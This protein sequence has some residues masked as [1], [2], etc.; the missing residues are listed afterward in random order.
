PSEFD[1]DAQLFG[2]FARCLGGRL[3]KPP[4][5]GC[6]GVPTASERV[7]QH[8]ALLQQHLLAAVAQHPA[9]EGHVPIAVRVDR[10]AWLGDASWLATFAEDFE[11]LGWIVLLDSHRQS[12]YEAAFEMCLRV[13]TVTWRNTD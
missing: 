1:V 12:A 10:G 13:D 3:A 4:V 7:L 6:R 2:N 8:R 5:A 9:V 11:Q